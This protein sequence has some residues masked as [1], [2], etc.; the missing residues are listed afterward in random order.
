[1]ARSLFWQRSE[2]LWA[3]TW[4]SKAPFLCVLSHLAP[5]AIKDELRVSARQ[6]VHEAFETSTS[7]QKEASLYAATGLV[8]R[9]R[10]R[11]VA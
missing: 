6:R 4:H 2:K 11:P 8:T 9:F 1:M 5:A 10:T 3:S 7:D